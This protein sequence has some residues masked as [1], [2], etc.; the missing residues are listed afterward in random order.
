MTCLQKKLLR[1][2]RAEQ[3]FMN[4]WGDAGDA[5]SYML[6][7]LWGHAIYSILVNRSV[8]TFSFCFATTK[9]TPPDS[10]SNGSD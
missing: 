8:I 4:T 1:P 6:D 2:Y 9:Y 5:P 10:P 3:A 7:P